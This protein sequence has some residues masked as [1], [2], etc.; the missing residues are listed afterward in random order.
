MKAKKLKGRD[1]VCDNTTKIK[2]GVLKN[3]EE[4]KTIR[5]YMLKKRRIDACERRRQKESRKKM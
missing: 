4:K 3:P 1:G 2:S 5:A